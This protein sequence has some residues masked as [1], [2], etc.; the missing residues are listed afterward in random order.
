M[1]FVATKL[2][3]NLTLYCRIV[4]FSRYKK[5]AKV[6]LFLIR[7]SWGNQDAGNFWVAPFPLAFLRRRLSGP[8][9]S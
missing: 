5:T 8:E 4:G 2:V 3:D 7:I 1:M 9:H 6:F